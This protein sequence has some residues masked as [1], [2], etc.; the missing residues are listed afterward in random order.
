MNIF[1]DM[2]NLASAHNLQALT[3]AALRYAHENVET[4]LQSQEF[5]K[6]PINQVQIILNL[7][8][9]RCDFS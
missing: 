3:K 5:L 8:S 9:M 2:A 6:S 7:L 1:S 4:V